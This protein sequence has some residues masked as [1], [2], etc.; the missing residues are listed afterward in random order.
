MLQAI[1]LRVHL[2]GDL[3]IAMPNRNGKD[4][5]KKIQILVPVKIPYVLHLTAV[6]HQRLF[7]V[8]GD[9]RPKEFFMLGYNFLT[10]RFCG[11]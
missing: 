5:A 2:G 3:R 9:R 1:D 6:G 8:V 11:A 10:A 7:K 4:A